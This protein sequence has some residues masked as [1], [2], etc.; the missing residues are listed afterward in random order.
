[1]SGD[2]NAISTDT[3]ILVKGTDSVVKT[4]DFPLVEGTYTVTLTNTTNIAS[5]STNTTYYQRVGTTVHVWGTFTAAATTGSTVCEMGF[6]L[7]V[8]SAFGSVFDGDGS[9]ASD[10]APVKII[11]DAT[12]D[13]MKFRFKPA[14]TSSTEYSFTLLINISL[15]NEVTIY[16]IIFIMLAD[17]SSANRGQHPDGGYRFG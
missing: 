4:L 6:S 2:N 17:F 8:A 13:R 16:H 1:M 9:G 3:K 14:N 12:N 5:S 15:H 10:D 11:A 7:P